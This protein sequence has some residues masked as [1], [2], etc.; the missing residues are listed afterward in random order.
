MDRGCAGMD[1]GKRSTTI[2][3]QSEDS[4]VST[5]AALSPRRYVSGVD[6]DLARQAVRAIGDIA[7]R[8]P[9]ASEPVVEALLE[10][11]EMEAE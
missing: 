9:A 2:I 8:V 6:A 3:F 10:L 5:Y 7:I 1:V 4:V 11:I